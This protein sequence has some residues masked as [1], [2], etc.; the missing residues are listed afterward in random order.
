MAEGDEC[1]SLVG[2][3]P[4]RRESIDHYLWGRAA[5]RFA[6]ISPAEHAG[7]VRK[8]GITTAMEVLLLAIAK[9]CGN[10]TCKWKKAKD[11]GIP[12]QENNG[13]L[14]IAV[15]QNTTGQW[16]RTSKS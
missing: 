10:N 11:L 12:W 14:C 1:V 4:R 5:L 9:V 2:A 3:P 15:C 7:L 6:G 8:L 13:R 16:R